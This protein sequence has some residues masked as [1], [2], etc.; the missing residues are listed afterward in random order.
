MRGP[1]CGCCAGPACGA[2]TP[3]TARYPYRTPC[4]TILV[5]FR[6]IRC[7]YNDASCA[8]H[9][10][11]WYGIFFVHEQQTNTMSVTQGTIRNVFYDNIATDVPATW[12][13]YEND[14][15][16]VNFHGI[17]RG[18]GYDILRGMPQDC[19]YTG[20]MDVLAEKNTDG[21]GN[22]HCT[23]KVDNPR[24]EYMTDPSTSQSNTCISGDYIYLFDPES[25]GTCNVATALQQIQSIS[26]Y[27]N[28]GDDGYDIS[29]NV[30]PPWV[31]PVQPQ[32]KP[33]PAPVPLPHRHHRH[34]G[35]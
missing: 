30:S 20:S 15:A 12:T 18:C 31:A 13:R 24:W 25:D 28:T 29:C 5:Q 8:H 27:P 32:P 14:K 6:C 22:T 2:R 33:A 4:C 19:L 23:L 11:S 34:R 9:I 3:A 26:L 16:N 35:H 21:G 1:C 17:K 10:R 7:L